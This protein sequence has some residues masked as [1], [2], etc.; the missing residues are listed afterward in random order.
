MTHRHGAKDASPSRKQRSLGFL[1]ILRPD[2]ECV[3]L[4]NGNRIAVRQR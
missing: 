3:K 4:A 2:L 1:T